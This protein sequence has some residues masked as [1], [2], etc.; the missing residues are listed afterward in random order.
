MR[1]IKPLAVKEI[2]AGAMQTENTPAGLAEGRLFFSYFKAF[3]KTFLMKSR[4][5][6][7]CVVSG[8][9]AVEPG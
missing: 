3:L 6:G 1:T 8:E 4:R 9:F 5:S 2:M 7:A